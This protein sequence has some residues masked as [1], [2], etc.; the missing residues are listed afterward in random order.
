LDRFS[1]LVIVCALRALA[2]RPTLWKT[3]DNSDNLLFKQSDFRD[4][5]NSPLFMEL[6]SISAVRELASRLESVLRSDY[7]SIPR[8]DDFLAGRVSLAKTAVTIPLASTISQAV[9]VSAIDRDRLLDLEGEVITVVGRVNEIH[10]GKDHKG[11]TY[12]FVNFG[13]WQRGDLALV[14]W[15]EAL[16]QTDPS[17]ASLRSYQGLSV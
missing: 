4:P 3:Y 5:E 8:I 16:L 7:S 6:R 12:A 2:E 14:L 11:R 10:F 1:I 17:G 13:D 15:P 9:V